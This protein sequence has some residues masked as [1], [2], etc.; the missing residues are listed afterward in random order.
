MEVFPEQVSDYRSNLK[1]ILDSFRPDFEKIE[2]VLSRH[3][4]SHIPLV[5]EIS[6]YILF[7]GGKRLR[8]LLTVCAARLLGRDDE[9]V[10]NLSAVPEYLHAASLLHDDVVDGGV[11]RRGRSPAYKIWGNNCL[12]YTSPS[13]RD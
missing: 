4:A 3:F 13:P 1:G 8:P 10:F 9:D 2:L 5:N 11:M 12:L 6:R 7:A